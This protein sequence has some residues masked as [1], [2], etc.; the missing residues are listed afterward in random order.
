LSLF[1]EESP[2][3][4]S[5]DLLERVPD[6]KSPPDG[7]SACVGH[8]HQDVPG[9]RPSL[10]CSPRLATVSGWSLILLLGGYSDEKTGRWCGV[11]VEGEVSE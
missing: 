6:G 3:P 2:E 5:L 1:S 7:S 4:S 8:S 9:Q 11:G 10:S